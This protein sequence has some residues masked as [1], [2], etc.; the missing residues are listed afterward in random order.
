[1]HHVTGGLNRFILTVL[2][3]LLFVGGLGWLAVLT[4]SRLGL[5]S[6]LGLVAPEGRI[7]VPP[8]T[9]TAGACLLGGIGL[10]IML[11]GTWFGLRQ[12]PRRGSVSGYSW[13]PPVDADTS[14]TTVV[15]ASALGHAIAQDA[16]GLTGV[17]HAKVLLFGAAAAPELLIQVSVDD[18]A[19]I[20][21][22]LTS[23]EDVV[24]PNAED[25]IGTPL[26]HVGVRVRTGGRSDSV[27]TVSITAPE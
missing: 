18:R 15:D 27:N 6:L 16:T 12:M 26:H 24:L 22:V 17:A 3:L 5:L 19:D 4:E 13:Q 11:L 25:A 10:L 9:G 8:L 2:G 20:T 7:I 21:A 1:M 23:L 14:G